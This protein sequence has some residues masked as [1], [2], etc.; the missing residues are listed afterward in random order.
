ML[1]CTCL[2]TPLSPEGEGACWLVFRGCLYIFTYP[3]KPIKGEGNFDNYRS[4]TPKCPSMRL[5]T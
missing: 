3:C 2:P 5:L 4:P 1:V